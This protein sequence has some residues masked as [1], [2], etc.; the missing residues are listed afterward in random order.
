MFRGRY[1]LPGI[2]FLALALRL[3]FFAVERPWDEPVE[4]GLVLAGDARGYHMMARTLLASGEFTYEPGDPPDA[5]R[6]PGYPGFIAAIYALFGPHPWIVLLFQTLLDVA[7]C[8]L[9]YRLASAAFGVVA[10]RWAAL[11]Y[12]LDPFLILQ[13]N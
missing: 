12:A 13:S 3:A 4:N 10:G 8:A 7:A 6:T 1:A 9:L 11:A 2:L 5:L